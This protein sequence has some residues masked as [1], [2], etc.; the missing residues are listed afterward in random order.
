M[1][2]DIFAYFVKESQQLIQELLALA[3]RLKNIDIPKEGE[4]REIAQLTQKLHRLIGGMA[5]IGFSMYSPVSRK[6]SI[7]AEKCTNIK[8]IP[9]TELVTNIFII[10]TDLSIYFYSNE[11]VREIEVKAADIEKRID[12]CMKLISL[13]KPH[14]TTQNE[15]DD[16]MKLFGNV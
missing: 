9:V 6:T 5:S 2:D 13:T 8:N 14:I 16:I 7:L 12:T 10:L 4:C 3:E 1:A 15:I 11:R